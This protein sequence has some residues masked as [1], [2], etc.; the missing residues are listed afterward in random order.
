MTQLAVPAWEKKD[1]ALKVDLNLASDE[2]TRAIQSRLQKSLGR[3]GGNQGV[4]AEHKPQAI[5]ADEGLGALWLDETT[6][7]HYRDHISGT[8]E[9]NASWS[10][11]GMQKEMSELAKEHSK[12]VNS[13]TGGEDVLYHSCEDFVCTCAFAGSTEASYF[14]WPSGKMIVR[15]ALTA[16]CLTTPP[17]RYFTIENAREIPESFFKPRSEWVRVDTGSHGA[18]GVDHSA[19]LDPNIVEVYHGLPVHRLPNFIAEGF[20]PTMGA[21]CDALLKH[22]GVLVMGSYQGKDIDTALTYPIAE[23]T[24]KVE[25]VDHLLGDKRKECAN[26]WGTSKKVS[27]GSLIADD[28]SYPFR[29]VIRSLADRRNQV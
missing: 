20:A 23:T 3:L 24:F 8:K 25:E 12:P 10:I 14:L 22:F 29:A 28:G 27:G 17:D 6:G 1:A 26:A 2:L 5:A 7:L 13:Y 11:E 18:E 9:V 15:Q 21:G 4:E 19:N 16:C